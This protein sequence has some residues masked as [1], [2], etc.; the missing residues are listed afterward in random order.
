M[1]VMNHLIVFQYAITVI[2]FQLRF[3]HHI[4]HLNQK[5]N[6]GKITIF[7]LLKNGLHTTQ[8]SEAH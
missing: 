6:T 4:L 7:H 2:I 5:W 8:S 1:Q 3:M